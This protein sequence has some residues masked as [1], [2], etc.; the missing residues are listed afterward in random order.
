V[1]QAKT[2]KMAIMF[3]P[4]LNSVLIL[5]KIC[6]KILSKAIQSIWWITMTGCYNSL[7]IKLVK[8]PAVLIWK[9]YQTTS[10][11]NRSH[12][13][14][15]L[16]YARDVFNVSQIYFSW[17]DFDT[18]RARAFHSVRFTFTSP[19]FLNSDTAT[20]LCLIY[21]VTISS[22]MARCAAIKVLGTIA[23]PV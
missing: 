15:I 22:Y 12:R 4:Q 1:F 7:V 10:I 14:Q 16:L 6:I 20:W 8:H 5:Q 21:F 11:S 19:H 3:V 2:T 23:I 17:V 18:G 13:Y 9:D